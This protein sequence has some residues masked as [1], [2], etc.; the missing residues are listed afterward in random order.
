MKIS[1]L[2]KQKSLIATF[3]IVAYVFLFG[4]SSNYDY[5]LLGLGL[6]SI[7]LTLIDNRD[8]DNSFLF[9]YIFAFIIWI[10]FSCYYSIDSERSL[11]FILIIL[12]AILLYN[13]IA[14]YL[15]MQHIYIIYFSLLLFSLLVSIYLLVIVINNI[16][17]SPQIWVQSVHLTFF[18]APNDIVFIII[19]LPASIIFIKKDSFFIVKIIAFLSIFIALCVVV[20]YQSRLAFLTIIISALWICSFRFKFKNIMLFL[21]LF[22][23]L[24]AIIDSLTGYAFINKINSYSWSTRLPLWLAAF[25]MFLKSPVT[26][27]GIGSYLLMYRD[28]LLNHGQLYLLNEDP[29]IT[30]WAHNLYL[31]VLAEMG[32]IG[33]LLLIAILYKSMKVSFMLI[34]DKTSE[35][36]LLALPTSTSIISFCFISFFELSLWKQ[37]VTIILFIFLGIVVNLKKNI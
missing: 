8:I 37:W 30:P 27:N 24:M 22:I 34:K 19:L 5:S 15:S 35:K 3:A 25:Y 21:F 17:A 18:K 28:S 31:E 16:N 14:S 32:S 10:S 20:F 9:Y 12:P 6:V 23:A 4:I 13:L 2:L 11:K 29:R 1:N 26:G 7:I 33:F 36:A